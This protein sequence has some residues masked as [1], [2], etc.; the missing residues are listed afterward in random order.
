MKFYLAP[1]LTHIHHRE[2]YM[3]LMKWGMNRKLICQH[4]YFRW[5]VVQGHVVFAQKLNLIVVASC[6]QL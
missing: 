2:Y 3:H 1:S 6:G 5:K 4:C